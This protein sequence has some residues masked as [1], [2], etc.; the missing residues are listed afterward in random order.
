[1]NECGGVSLF[2][3]EQSMNHISL[4]KRPRCYA[5]ALGVKG[6]NKNYSRT[7]VKGQL[8]LP[9]EEETNLIGWFKFAFTKVCHESD[10]PCCLLGY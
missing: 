4:K 7:K 6:L 8:L 2:I 3:H 5:C 1:M 10:L 9:R